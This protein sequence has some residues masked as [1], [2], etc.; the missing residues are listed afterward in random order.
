MIKRRFLPT[1]QMSIMQCVIT[2]DGLI[3]EISCFVVGIIIII[4]SNVIARISFK[5]WLFI[6]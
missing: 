2:A 6:E 1:N 3:K 5:G 4:I